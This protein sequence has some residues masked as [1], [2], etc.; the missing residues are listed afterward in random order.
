M[1]RFSTGLRNAL[2]TNY[3][4]GTMMNG[5]IIRVYSGTIP[6]TPDNVPN[7]NEIARITTEGKVFY[8]GNDINNAGLMLAH[9]SPG[10]LIQVGD[11]IMKGV[12]AGVAS[13]WRWNWSGVDANTLS[14]LHPRIDGKV[15][16]S[17]N[18]VSKNITTSTQ[19]TI[20][21]FLFILPMGS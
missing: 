9:V 3:G 15:G 13:W 1:A 8:P 21:Q 10:T 5:G 6:A 18:L 20:E 11:W 19:V 12:G 4:L 7:G 14:T 16:V 17:L 2:T